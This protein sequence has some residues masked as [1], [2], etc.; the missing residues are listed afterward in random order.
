MR[1][2]NTHD[3]CVNVLVAESPPLKGHETTIL[4]GMGDMQVVTSPGVVAAAALGPSLG[5][6]V[7]HPK[8]LKAVAAH[9]FPMGAS[10]EELASLIAAVKKEFRTF[11]ELR[12]Y[13]AGA[14]IFPEIEGTECENFTLKGRDQFVEAFKNLGVVATSIFARWCKKGEEATQDILLN[15][16]SG[17]VNYA[18]YDL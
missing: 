5:V 6:I 14:Q 3:S 1:V 11:R 13:L 7:Y 10:E 17:E 18:E 9:F 8:E 15:L 4:D 12:V 2:K 16:A